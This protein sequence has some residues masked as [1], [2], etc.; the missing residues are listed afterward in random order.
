MKKIVATMMLIFA[1]MFVVAPNVRAAESTVETHTPAEIREYLKENN[2]KTD[3]TT[4][5]SATPQTVAPYALGSLSDET[6]TS[7][8]ATLNAVR[9][10]AGLNYDVVID[11]NCQEK[12]QAAALINA[13]N[14][15]LAHSQNQPS[16]MDD[17]LFAI[18]DEGCHSTN[19]GLGYRNLNSAII[20]GWMS[21]R[22]PSNVQLVGHRRWLLNPPM[23]KTGFGVATKDRTFSAVYAHDRSS[24]T[25]ATGVAWPAQ[26][27]PISFFYRSNEPW[28]VS[29]GVRQD[30]TKVKVILTRVSDGKTW[31][32][33]HNDTTDG[34]FYVD[35]GG[36]GQTGCIIFRPTIDT[37]Y[38]DGDKFNVEISGLYNRN[39]QAY[40]DTLKYSVYFFDSEADTTVSLSKDSISIDESKTT[41]LTAKVYPLDILEQNTE[42]LNCT[43][44]DASI[45]DVRVDGNVITVTG[46]NAGS[47]VLT[48]SIDGKTVNCPITVSHV[49]GNAATC[50][51]PQTCMICHALL[52]AA[53]GHD[54]GDPEF[55]FSNNHTEATAKFICENCQEE[56]IRNA[57]VTSKTTN[58][59]CMQD[60]KTVYTASVEFNGQ[61]YTDTEEETIPATGHRFVAKNIEFSSD[62]N[63]ANLKLICDIC[64]EIKYEPA[65]V[66][67]VT[68]D[69]TCTVDGERV[70]TAEAS[71]NGKVF[72]DTKTIVLPAGHEYSSPIFTFLGDY[73]S[74]EASFSCR[75]CGITETKT[76]TVISQTTEPTYYAEGKTVYTATVD[77]NGMKYTKEETITIP[78]LTM[79]N[80]QN[81][82]ASE[83]TQANNNNI[84]NNASSSNIQITG[85]SRQIAAGKK[86]QLTVTGSN[87]DEFIWTSSNPSLATVDRN[88][89]VK[90][91]KRAKGKTITIT[92]TTRNGMKATFTIKGMKGIVKKIKIKGK[93]TVTAGK[94]LKLRAKIKATKGAN[95]KLVWTSSNTRY[96]TVTK[97]GKVKTKAAAK[98][99]KV[100]ITAMA[101]DG[102]NKQKSIVIKIK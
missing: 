56:Q 94:K 96:A 17:E 32:F 80:Q 41:S 87:Q 42:G 14:D 93:K 48:V 60:G 47:A 102:S 75:K 73:T 53:T 25:T 91:N 100:R 26:N 3:D 12:A 83:S 16:D 68:T 95:K 61:K 40:D 89:L 70:F 66:S 72:R 82:S 52:K 33:S 19:L 54:Y 9:Y 39:T 6:T 76:A 21:D 38:K 71:Y 1:G 79:S 63:T 13:V 67:V 86:I 58:P 46:K 84:S 27:T 11:S 62:Y 29:M 45:A 69:A 22:D 23:Q 43:I 65:V 74:A 31:R 50:T 78:K 30:V 2:V 64:S 34:D 98:G 97:K 44:N 15:T 28:S 59:T 88:G 57:T 10:I 8:L 90:L 77:F 5:Y 37:E 18:C 20:D 36:Y 99:K 4:T 101:T 55:I 81:P 7:A 92:A 85:I 35:N 49:P 24:T 51:T